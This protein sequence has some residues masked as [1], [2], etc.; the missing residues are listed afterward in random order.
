MSAGSDESYF[1]LILIPNEEPVGFDMTFPIGGE[2]SNQA[3]GFVAWVKWCSSTN[4]F[5]DIF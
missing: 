3:V 1:F 5:D 2:C 4:F